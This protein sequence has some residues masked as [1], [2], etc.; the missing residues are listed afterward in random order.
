MTG[1]NAEHGTKGPSGLYI[2]SHSVPR[3]ARLRCAVHPR[4]LRSPWPHGT[5][6]AEGQALNRAADHASVRAEP[7]PV[8]YL[9]NRSNL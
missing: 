9:D 1:R 2:S 8:G 3:D 7:L 5:S 4:S 6:Q